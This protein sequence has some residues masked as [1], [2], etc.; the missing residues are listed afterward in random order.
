MSVVIYV[1]VSEGI[2]IAADSMSIIGGEI[3]TPDGK[4][5]QGILKTFEHAK[6]VSHLSTYPIGTLAWGLGQIGLRTIES[7]IKEFET[8]PESKVDDFTVKDLAYKLCKF[9]KE[10]YDVAFKDITNIRQK[11]VLGV[12]VCGFS[13][14]KYF[15]EDYRLILP[16]DKEPTILRED[17]PDG[18]PN[19][20][21]NWYGLTEPIVRFF[22]GYDPR[23]RA[24]LESNGIAPDKAKE[25]INGFQ[26]PVVFPAMPLQDA[27]DFASFLVE[28]CIWRNRFVI[29]APQVGG[30]VDVAVITHDKF[31][32]VSRKEWQPVWV[33]RK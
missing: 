10:R 8:T 3:Q 9:I 26:Y 21:A 6:K 31:D 2:V 5:S 1:K 33:Q 19:F 13:K 11:P 12:I 4:V 16:R 18:N 14:E 7:L 23:L 17:S 22:L 28:L 20:G 24:I 32:W 30:N 15:A 27:I 29:G 25:I